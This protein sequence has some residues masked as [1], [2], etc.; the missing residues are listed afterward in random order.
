MNEKKNAIQTN[1]QLIG[2]RIDTTVVTSHQLVAIL[3]KRHKEH[4]LYRNKKTLNQSVLQPV[5]C[6]P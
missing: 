1:D 2:I 4:Q 3:F 6:S 5:V